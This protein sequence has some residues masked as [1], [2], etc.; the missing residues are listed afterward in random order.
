VDQ[1]LVGD[2]GDDY[3]SGGFKNDN[4]LILA[5]DGDDFVRTQK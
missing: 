2:E 3:I 4:L 1:Y 5:G